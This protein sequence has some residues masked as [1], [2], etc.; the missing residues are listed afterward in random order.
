MCPVC[1][2]KVEVHT[3]FM[4]RLLFTAPQPRA[5]LGDDDEVCIT[6]YIISLYFGEFAN[7]ALATTGL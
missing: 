5:G 3:Q 7:F 1:Q 4:P 6:L 2:R